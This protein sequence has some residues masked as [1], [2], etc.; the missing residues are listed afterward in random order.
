[1]ISLPMGM[2]AD[3]NIYMVSESTGLDSVV[4]VKGG[5][6]VGEDMT[7]LVHAAIKSASDLSGVDDF[8]AM[9]DAEIDDYLAS[10][11]EDEEDE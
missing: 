6:R 3:F 11:E 4:T 5:K 7:P 2:R 8:R 1:M 10:Q 9:T